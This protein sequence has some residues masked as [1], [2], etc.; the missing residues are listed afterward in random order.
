MVLNICLNQENDLDHTLNSMVFLNSTGLQE[1]SESFIH[2]VWLELQCKVNFNFT[3]VGSN[4]TLR[5]KVAEWLSIFVQVRVL[6]PELF[7][8]VEWVDTL[9]W[10]HVK[11][12]RAYCFG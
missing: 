10:V 6:L 5:N 2:S 3:Y 8:M 1:E 12:G 9:D 11:K 4:P 7:G